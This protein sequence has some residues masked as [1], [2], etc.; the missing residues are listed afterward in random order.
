MSESPVE[1]SATAQR[2]EQIAEGPRG[3]K[4]THFFQTGLGLFGQI[5]QSR[6]Q[7]RMHKAKRNERAVVGKRSVYPVPP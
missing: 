3:E 6:P 4:E 5:W 1:E 7:R 2:P